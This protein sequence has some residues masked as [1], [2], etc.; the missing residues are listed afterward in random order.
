[1][2]TI[3]HVKHALIIDDSEDMQELLT[4][5]LQSKGYQT[6]CTSNGEEALSLLNSCESLPSVILVDFRM[7]VMDG[8]SFIQMQRD[9]PRLKNI[10]VIMMTAED[11]HGIFASCRR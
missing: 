9:C 11:E 6:D 5:L 10:P 2:N 8:C 1:M 3:P 4:L 7:P